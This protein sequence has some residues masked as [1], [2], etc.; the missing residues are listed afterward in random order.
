[1]KEID[2]LNLDRK[3]TYEWFNS[4]SNPTYGVNVR[5]D[6]SNVVRYSKEN[7]ISFF[8]LFLYLITKSMNEVKEM[9]MRF[10]GGKPVIFESINPAVTVMTKNE[11]FENVNLNY[12]EEFNKFYNEGKKLIDEAKNEEVLKKT[13]YNECN[14]WD[15]YYITCLPWLDFNSVT[16]PI[17]L[18]KSSLSVPRICWGKYILENNKYMMSLNITVSHTFVDGFHLYK[19]IRNLEENVLKLY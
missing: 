4:F 11:V 18:D 8:I 13:S 9:R 6:V 3:K 15:Y 2:V 1:M 12:Y 5:I 10:V 14:R 7:N 19:V 16:H 17:P